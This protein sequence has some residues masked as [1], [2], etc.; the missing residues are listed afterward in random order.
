MILQHVCSW[1]LC[2]FLRIR[3]I[4][5]NLD[6]PYLGTFGINGLSLLTYH[7]TR[8]I[9]ESCDAV[10]GNRSRSGHA[11]RLVG[12][13][14]FGARQSSGRWSFSQSQ[15]LALFYQ[16]RRAVGVIRHCTVARI[17]K[18]KLLAK[19]KL[20]ARDSQYNGPQSVQMPSIK[21]ANPPR[22]SSIVPDD[23]R[24]YM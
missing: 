1:Q 3:A 4:I 20:C 7:S 5:P 12:K 19:S 6:F 11:I 10:D 21:Y 17:A 18:G 9:L 23:P 15:K 14:A 13:S 22:T 24:R 2:K 8:Q 16:D